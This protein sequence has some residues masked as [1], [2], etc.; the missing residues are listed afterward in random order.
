MSDEI[1]A[2][3]KELH[4]LNHNLHLKAHEV[5]KTVDSIKY[6]HASENLFSDVNPL[7]PKFVVNDA[8]IIHSED[9]IPKINKQLKTLV[10]VSDIPSVECI[11]D[12][13]ILKKDNNMEN[14]AVITLLK[15]KIDML[16]KKLEIMQLE[17]N[18]KCDYYKELEVEKKKLD[19]VQV[20]LRNQIETLNDTITK[21]ERINSDIL[22]DSQILSK[23]NIILKKDLEN[24]RKEIRTLNQQSTNLDV[25]LNKSLDNNE[26]LRNELKC[27]Q[28]K[29]KEL[30]K[31]I[32]KMQ[33]DKELAIKNLEEQRWKLSQAFKKQTLLVDNLKKQNGM[34]ERLQNLD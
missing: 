30:L 4:R 21:L 28:I 11:N 34:L 26:K 20:K 27:S 31:Q 5:M 16:Y 19:D 23:E 9:V 8:K 25:R 13:E 18:N 6:V 12:N 33:E 17:Y 3:E 32:R 7:L 14:K 22:S 15:G 29:E 24:L 2:K 10:K 1:L